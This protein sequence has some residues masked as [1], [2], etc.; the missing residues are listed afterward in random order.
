MATWD[1]A[2]IEKIGW[3]WTGVIWLYDILTYML[4]D[5]IKFGVRCAVSGSAWGLVLYYNEA[6]IFSHNFDL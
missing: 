6:K 3:D 2:G 5:P 4:L 1:V